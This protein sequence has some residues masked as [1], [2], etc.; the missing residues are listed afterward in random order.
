[1]YLRMYFTQCIHTSHNLIYTWPHSIGQGVDLVFLEELVGAVE[2]LP[3]AAIGVDLQNVHLS[4]AK[5]WGASS[6]FEATW[7]KHG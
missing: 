2:D 6:L 3:F 4:T 5:T 1:M 7:P